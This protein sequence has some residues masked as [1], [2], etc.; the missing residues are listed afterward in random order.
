[1]KI[2]DFVVGRNVEKQAVYRYLVRHRDLYDRCER[3]G[4]GKDLDIPDDVVQALDQ[5]YPVAKPV[6]VINGLSPEDE[7]Q[8]RDQL[9][10]TQEQLI[11]VQSQLTNTLQQLSQQQ[12]A[13]YMLDSKQERIKELEAEIEQLQNRSFLQRLFNF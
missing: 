10:R 5:Q 4:N 8:L 2:S 9:A 12:H 3:N 1:M 11:A 6:I 13:V 7:R